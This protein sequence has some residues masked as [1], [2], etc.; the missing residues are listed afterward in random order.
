MKFRRCAWEKSPTVEVGPRQ[1]AA[2]ARRLARQREAVALLP[3]LVA[4]VP[5][6]A[7]ELAYMRTGIPEE[8]AYWRALHA[9]AWRRARRELEALPE[10]TRRGILRYWDRFSE[11]SAADPCYLLSFIREAKRG[12]SFWAR[13]RHLRLMELIGER[14]LPPNWFEGRPKEPPWRMRD[15]LDHD[16]ERFR[17]KRS[18]KRGLLT[19]ERQLML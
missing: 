16:V 9:A 15:Y 10:H 5:T 13:L 19:T 18:R 7:D 6:I 14:R 4:A 17:R 8:H 1:L 11:R 2:A 3:D 12:V